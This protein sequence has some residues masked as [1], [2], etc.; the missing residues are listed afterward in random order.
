MG[1]GSYL[2][3]LA[4]AELKIKLK[5]GKDRM[6]R[7]QAPTGDPESRITGNKNQELI[8]GGTSA[9]VQANLANSEGCSERLFDMLIG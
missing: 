5:A 8:D 3:G 4:S 1:R 6:M 7:L 9:H 2:G